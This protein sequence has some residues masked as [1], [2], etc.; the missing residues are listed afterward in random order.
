VLTVAV[1]ATPL[2]GARTGVGAFTA[3]TLRA[4]AGHPDLA[5]LGYGLTWAGRRQLAAALP[6]GV[7]P[8]RAPMAAAPLLALWRAM[9]GPAIEWWS[10][11]VDVVHGT[12]YVV[13]PSR[14]AAR[15]V[16]VH[17]LTPLRFPELC[18]P[19]SRAYPALI[20][21]AIDGGAV[22]HTP[23]EAVAAEVVELLGAP[24]E[25]VRFVHY[26]FDREALTHPG[27]RP[28]GPPYV[29]GLG[30]VEPRKDFPGLVRAFDQVAATHPDVILVIAGPSGWGEAA[31]A[32][33]IDGA[34]HRDRIRRVGWVPDDQRATLLAHASVFAYPSVYEGFGLPPLEAMACGVPVVATAVPAVAEVTAGAA[35]LVGVGDEA[36]LAAALAEVLDDGEERRR[37]I[38]A[39]RARVGMF[40]WAR[41]ADGVAQIY[42]EARARQ[43]S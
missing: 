3:G 14:R 22:V 15:V 24:R 16:T 1:D 42:R 39:G 5:L 34:V 11:A 29:L 9:D 13:P 38:V 31:L 40:T 6:G 25:Q 17:D 10:G 8:I 32:A 23:T 28:A 18:S 36:G 21:R 35:R 19:A 27:P 12:N 2:L 7:R 43:S 20:R 4:L 41:C 37:L 26:G 30:T 33:A